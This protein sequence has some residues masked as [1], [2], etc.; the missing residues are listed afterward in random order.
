MGR[1][2]A[3]EIQSVRW[4]VPWR[5]VRE[6]TLRAIREDDGQVDSKADMVDRNVRRPGRQWV[7]C[8]YQQVG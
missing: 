8:A 6:I 1:H 5:Y 4:E 3:T 2:Y 7:A